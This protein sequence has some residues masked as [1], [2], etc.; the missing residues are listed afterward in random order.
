MTA[1]S[2]K[3]ACTGPFSPSPS[4][5]P[6]KENLAAT[7]EVSNIVPDV[8]ISPPA[9]LIFS[10]NHPTDQEP[11]QDLQ[12]HIPEDPKQEAFFDLDDVVPT[13]LIPQYTPFV[14]KAGVYQELSCL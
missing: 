14:K 13:P 7:P 4:S 9:K 3:N 1:K 12:T 2:N 11:F 8:D 10:I 6:A 5:P